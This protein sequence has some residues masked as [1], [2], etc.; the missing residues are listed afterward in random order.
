M[1]QKMYKTYIMVVVK[2]ATGGLDRK[3]VTAWINTLF[4]GAR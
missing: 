2:Q 4:L 1:Y 3:I